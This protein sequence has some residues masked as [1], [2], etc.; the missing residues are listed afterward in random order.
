M[1][2]FI[3]EQESNTTVNDTISYINC[4]TSPGGTQAADIAGKSAWSAFRGA[5]PGGG[6]GSGLRPPPFADNV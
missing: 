6:T 3:T 1:K 4:I 5:N 2:I